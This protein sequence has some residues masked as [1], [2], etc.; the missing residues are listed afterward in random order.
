MVNLVFP[1]DNLLLNSKIDEE[2]QILKS[3]RGA[4]TIE[5]NFSCLKIQFLFTFL[6]ISRLYVYDNNT[7]VGYITKEDFVRRSMIIN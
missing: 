2:D 5:K 1:E 7:L 4:L 6:N 3:D